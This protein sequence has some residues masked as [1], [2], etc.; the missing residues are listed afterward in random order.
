MGVGN[1]KVVVVFLHKGIKTGVCLY[2]SEAVPER[3]TLG[4]V[5]LKILGKFSAGKAFKG[6]LRKAFKHT[7]LTVGIVGS[8]TCKAPD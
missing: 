7:T 6:K 5:G 4:R 8:L 2:T 3:K 1:K